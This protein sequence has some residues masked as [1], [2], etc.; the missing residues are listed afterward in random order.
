MAVVRSSTQLGRLLREARS[1]RGLSQRELASLAGCSQRFLSELERG[2]STAEIGK[3]FDVLEALELL[4]D[5]T[6]S[7]DAVSSLV[8]RT[9]AQ[10]V[11]RSRAE[12]HL[13]DYLEAR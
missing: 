7:Q 3:V 8:A 11:A 10:I 9:E 2:K 6:S 5:V 13:A 12:T 1:A 4:V